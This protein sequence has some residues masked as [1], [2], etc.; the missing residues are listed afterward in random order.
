MKTQKCSVGKEKIM[1]KIISLLLVLCMAVGIVA[2]GS[3]Q[4]EAPEA[5]PAE[6]EAPSE[7]S[8]ES[9]KQGAYELIFVCPIVGLEYWDM[10]ADGIAAADA[11]FGTKTQIVGPTDPST[12]ATEVVNYIEAAISS[13]P[14]GIMTYCGLETVPPLIEKADGLGIP[15]MAIDSD[16]PDSARI[17]YVGTDPYNAGYKTGEA[18]IDAMG[19]SGKIAILCSGISA[20]KEMT[21]IDAF[22]EAI[23]DCD[24]EVI[25][26]EE[27]NADLAT[28][29]V[30]MEA[31]V[32]TYPE[33]T[34]VLCTSAYDVQ[35]AAK[36]KEEMGL[37]DL[38]LI[39]YDDQEETLNYIRKGTIN[40]IVVQ[41]PYQMGYQGVKLMKQYLDGE[42][43]ESDV[44]DTGTILVTQENVDNYR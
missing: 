3:K 13:Q 40:A 44:F 19:K 43:L 4:E 38:V 24:I 1:K 8:V 29:V 18:M 10:C 32:Q 14:D 23:A 7:E 27:T 21:E 6:A 35:A 28:G 2:C 15:F 41:D 16:A 5:D 9:T 33:M 17:A 12:F 11:E 36:V 42:I 25:A 39:G 30:K 34:G 20:E 26:M 31:L 22:K 37:D